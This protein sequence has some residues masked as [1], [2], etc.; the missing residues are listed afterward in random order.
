MIR[1]NKITVHCYVCQRK[2]K[3]M[4]TIEYNIPA[5]KTCRLQ[6]FGQPPAQ[7]LFLDIETTG[8]SPKNASVYLIGCAFYKE[9]QWCVRQYFAQTQVQEEEIL[10][11]FYTFSSSFS[12]CVHFN[13]QAFDVPFLQE[14]YKKHA[15]PPFM[16]QSQCDIYKAIRPYKNLM[17]LPGCRQK[18]LEAYLG[19]DRE[20]PFT[21]GQL[22]ELYHA[23]EAQQDETLL[24]T[25]LLHNLEDLV[26]MMQLSRI[27][28]IPFLFEG[29]HFLP[30]EI[31]L[32]DAK[33]TATTQKAECL[34]HLAAD[35]PLPVPL[36]CH[37]QKGILS[38]CFF[39]ARE[40]AAVLKLPVFAGELKYFYP[41]YKNYAYLPMEDEAIH[42]S[43][44]IYVDKSR[45]MPATKETCYTKKK[46]QYLPAV[47]PLPDGIPLF[48]PDY[49]ERCHWFMANE[50]FLS[51]QTFQKQYI[52]N[53]LK[54]LGKTRS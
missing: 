15:L 27:M 54:I 26:G 14:R 5:D 31:L 23:Y 43:V 17:R 22:I 36:A 52:Q 30:E 20:D 28:A 38:E 9:G 48:G 34:I 41:D 4:K 3:T 16:P 13:G 6:T 1:I 2:T 21:G 29:G 33:D 11:A 44:A 49:P 42:K 45:R 32:Q 19:L 25:I 50:A 53:I 24:K 40:L 37:G 12:H 8:F 51:D 47:L 10:R 35:F 7:I 39:S 46:G 18:Q